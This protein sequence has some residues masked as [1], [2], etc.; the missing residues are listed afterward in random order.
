MRSKWRRR[1]CPLA[2]AVVMLAACGS[3]KSSSSAAG[4]SGGG[5][6]SSAP[7]G[8]ASTGTTKAADPN[9]TPVTVG[10]ANLEGGAVS[11]PEVRV[12]FEQGLKY[13]N[14]ELGGLNGHQIKVASCK[15]DLTPESSV[16]CANQFV[17]KNVVAE[18]Q[19]VDVVADAGL[20]VIQKA[21]IPQIGIVSFTPNVNKAK[22]DVF[23]TLWSPEEGI[24][25]ALIA[26]K[27]LGAKKV[28]LGL[29]DTAG[30]RAFEGSIVKP[31]AQ[32]LSMQVQ[33]VYYPAQTDWASFSATILAKSPEGVSF[34]SIDD[35]DCLG[36]IPAFKAAGWSGPL[37]AGSCNQF[38]TKLDP[39]TAAGV[40]THDEYYWP[41]MLNDSSPAK[42][43]QDV[44][45]YKRY[46]KDFPQYV[47]GFATLGFSLA[48]NAADMMRQT[49]GE[50]TAPNL[51]TSL[52][53]AH[54]PEFFNTTS[55]NCESAG[56][57]GTTSC[58]SGVLYAKA[59]KDRTKTVL[60]FS[61]VDVSAVRPKG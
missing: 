13:V 50:L 20:P 1:L 38:L 37:E 15:T 43:K 49:Q 46:M 29:S 14:S 48:V 51:K 11:L 32:Q 36:M 10:F 42:V 52:P 24:T 25:A 4:S 30:N 39:G 2:V 18:I 47:D 21:G 35:Q 9:A 28:V 56:W 45:T 55:Y 34:P 19:G 60:Q 61:P 31:I 53:K 33:V 41:S 40:I 16:N 23:M 44:A 54:G 7:G 26:Q 5:S 22:G 59:T 27:N 3:S 6:T 12:G 17:E 58:Y 57:P 8:S